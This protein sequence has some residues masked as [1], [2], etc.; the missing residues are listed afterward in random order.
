ML[1]RLDAQSFPDTRAWN[2]DEI[3]ASQRPM[4][5]WRIRS[6]R[7]TSRLALLSWPKLPIHDDPAALDLFLA[8]PQRPDREPVLVMGAA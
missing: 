6:L 2:G 7:E 8:D 4:S 1:K 5:A 3:G